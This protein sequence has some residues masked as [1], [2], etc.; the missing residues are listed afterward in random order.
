M[1]SNNVIIIQHKKW[2]RCKYGWLEWSS[3]YP[4][5]RWLSQFP[6]QVS[7][8]I[9]AILNLKVEE[10]CKKKCTLYSYCLK[11]IRIMFISCCCVVVV[12]TISFNTLFFYF[13]SDSHFSVCF[14]LRTSV[15]YD[16]VSNGNSH[17]MLQ[18]SVFQ[19]LQFH[20]GDSFEWGWFRLFGVLDLSCSHL[21]FL[22]SSIFFSKM[23]LACL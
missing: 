13:I 4:F 1:L 15:G 23:W 17:F 19:I 10:L 12:F 11:K 2:K 21:F 18:N 20:L 7:S 16:N 22:F 6:C 5:E 3:M 9:L 8:L 14:G